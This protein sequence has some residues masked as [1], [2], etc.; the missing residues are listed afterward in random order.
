[1]ALA[2]LGSVLEAY[3]R[4]EGRGRMYSW[5]RHAHDGFVG[6]HVVRAAGRLFLALFL[7]YFDWSVAQQP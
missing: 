3:Q 2:I 7:T 6:F 1:M 4:V 5:K